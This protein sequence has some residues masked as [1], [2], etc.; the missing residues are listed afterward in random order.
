MKIQKLSHLMNRYLPSLGLA[1]LIAIPIFT[2]ADAIA[3]NPTGG[4]AVTTSIGR[5]ASEFSAGGMSVGSGVNAIKTKKVGMKGNT[6]G[7]QKD[8]N[9]TGVGTDC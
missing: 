5:K 1:L 2:P 9:C 4:Q 3:E 8:G 7:S 6:G